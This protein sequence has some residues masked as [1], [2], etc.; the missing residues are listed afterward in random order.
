MLMRGE[1]RSAVRQSTSVSLKVAS[2]PAPVIRWQYLSN[3]P[4][5]HDLHKEQT[6]WSHTYLSIARARARVRTELLRAGSESE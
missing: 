2:I 6:S 1:A 4:Y 5:D 3:A